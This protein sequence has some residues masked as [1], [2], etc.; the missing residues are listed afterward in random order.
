MLDYHSAIDSDEEDDGIL[1]NPFVIDDDMLRSVDAWSSEDEDD[2]RFVDPALLRL[3]RIDTD[4]AERDDVTKYSI[5]SP[6]YEE[7]RTMADRCR[8][9]G[10]IL[11]RST[12]APSM[13]SKLSK[14]SAKSLSRT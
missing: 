14:R 9:V 11:K 4:I 10:S 3:D 2:E 6:H 1:D 13:Y 12:L 5:V 8:S 7:E